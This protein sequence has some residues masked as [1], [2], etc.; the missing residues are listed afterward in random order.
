MQDLVDQ[1]T[2]ISKAFFGYAYPT[3]GP[4]PTKPS[5]NFVNSFEKIEPVPV[6]PEHGGRRCSRP[7]AGRSTR[8]ATSTCTS[9]GTG[10]GQCGAGIPQGAKASFSLQYESGQ[11]SLDQEMAQFKTDFALAGIAID[12][13]TAP[14]DTVIGNATPCKTGS[15]CTWDMEFWGGGWIYAPDYEP[16]GDELWSCTGSGASVQYAGSDSG[17]YCD[18]QAESDILATET[19]RQRVGHVHVR[20]LPRQ[21]ASGHL[22]AGR[23]RATVR[24]QQGSEG[25]R[26]RRIRCCRS[27]RRTGAGPDPA[28]NQPANRTGDAGAEPASPFD[29]QWRAEPV[30]CSLPCR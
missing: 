11:P 24:D 16:T 1:N 22:A 28:L 12:L 9:P 17:G 29:S 6:Q 3:Y 20:G 13:T 5:S 27:T 2:F 26:R 21:A 4:V 18:P 25:H 7:T 15:P 14:F 10:T 23:V 8:A 30:V 19:S